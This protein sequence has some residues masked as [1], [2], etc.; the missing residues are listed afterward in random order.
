MVIHQGDMFWLDMGIPDGSQP[1]YRRP[2]VVVQNNAFNISQIH[3][4]VVC[5][6]TSKVRLSNAPGNILL[7][8]GEGNLP[9]RS[10]VN[11]SQLFTV[12]KDELEEFIGT[13]S[14]DRMRDILNGVAFLLEPRDP[15]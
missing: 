6:M 14:T 8:E 10:V 13:L 5:G 3:T 7:R 2:H 4:V 11:V 12:H 15:K 1:E 9:K